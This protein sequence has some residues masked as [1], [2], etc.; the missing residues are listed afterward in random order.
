[1]QIVLIDLCE[2]KSGLTEVESCQLTDNYFYR[3]LKMLEMQKIPIKNRYEY[4]KTTPQQLE[5]DI[6][7]IFNPIMYK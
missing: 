3:I 5:Q 1:M 2:I 6:N 4:G 7:C